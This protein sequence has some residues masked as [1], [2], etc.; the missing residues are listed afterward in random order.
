MKCRLLG[1]HLR[2]I[3]S[4]VTQGSFLFIPSEQPAFPTELVRWASGTLEV[5][6]LTLTAGIRIT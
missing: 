5:H 2:E 1:G 6:G 3:R 4:G